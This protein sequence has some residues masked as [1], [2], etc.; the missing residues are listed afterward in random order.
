MSLPASVLSSLKEHSPIIEEIIIKTLST[1]NQEKLQS[2]MLYLVESGGKR[3]RA[4]LP[5]L[6]VIFWEP[7]HSHYEVGAAIE[8][9]HNF[10]LSMMILWMMI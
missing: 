7:D 10:T 3:L 9:I 5:Y 2:A 4:S 1:S 8:I 6:L